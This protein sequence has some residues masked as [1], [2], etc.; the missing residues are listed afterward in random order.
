MGS[1]MSQS[2]SARRTFNSLLLLAIATCVMSTGC[3]AL[4]SMAGK[5]LPVEGTV[6]K[7][8]G[9]GS[10]SVEMHPN[11]GSPKK[12]DGTLV[13]GDTVSAAL[14]KA[15]AIK[16]FRSM[17]IEIL[18]IVEKD[19]RNRGLRMPVIYESHL[20]APAPEQDYALLDGDRIVVKPKESGSLVQMLGNMIN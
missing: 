8:A 9:L 6:A 12:Y 20:K 16:K 17:D 10:Y 18:R 7:S 19:G 4:S 11:L 3:S 5:P 13:A 14:V 1:L 2:L 15:G